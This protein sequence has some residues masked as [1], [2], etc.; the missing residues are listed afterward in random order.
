MFS[1]SFLY[2]GI[3]GRTIMINIYQLLQNKRQL[4]NSPVFEDSD[5][6]FMTYLKVGIPFLDDL[7]YLK[8]LSLIEPKFSLF[9]WLTY[10]LVLLSGETQN[11]T[12]FSSEYGSTIPDRQFQKS[13]RLCK[14]KINV[15]VWHKFIWQ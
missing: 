10:T 6:E 9:L 8:V 12:I 5:W 3:R 1:F 2:V 14:L 7:C 15:N 11:K 4:Y 13:K